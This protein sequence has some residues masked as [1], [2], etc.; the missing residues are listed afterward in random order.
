MTDH[1]RREAARLDYINGAGTYAEIAERHGMTINKLR[2]YINREGWKAERDEFIAQRNALAIEKAAEQAADKLAEQSATRREGLH[3]AFMELLGRLPTLGGKE[4]YTAA[5]A[6]GIV[7]DKLHKE[8]G[9]LQPAESGSSASSAAL[10]T[11]QQFVEGRISNDEI[12]AQ[13]GLRA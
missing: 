5:T 7:H 1:E 13:A 2:G 12:I 11:I 6:L 8:L 4:L 10:V 9:T 3:E